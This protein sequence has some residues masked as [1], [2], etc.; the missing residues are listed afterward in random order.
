MFHLHSDAVALKQPLTGGS[1]R[2]R[3]EPEPLTKHSGWSL[4]PELQTP[5]GIA[6]GI[7]VPGQ[8]PHGARVH[9]PPPHTYM[10]SS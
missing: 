8:Q 5:L 2:T 3:K 10:Y 6:S 1:A 9:T 4:A 7:A